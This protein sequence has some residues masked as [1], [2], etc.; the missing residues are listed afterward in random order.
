[1]IPTATFIA[2]F[3]TKSLHDPIEGIGD[4]ENASKK[5]KEASQKTKSN[6]YLAHWARMAPIIEGGIEAPLQFLLQVK[7]TLST[8]KTFKYNKLLILDN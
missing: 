5:K 6:R 8:I 1:M 4:Q 2:V 3:W 7:L